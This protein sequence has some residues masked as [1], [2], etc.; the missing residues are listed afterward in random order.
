MV[1]AGN[2]QIV[3]KANAMPGRY[4]VTVNA[5]YDID[6]VRAYAAQLGGTVT[7]VWYYAVFGFAMQ[8]STQVATTL[9]LDSRVTAVEQD[10]A[11][12]S[13][14]VCPITQHYPSQTCA[15]GSIPWQLD[16]MDSSAGTTPDE[17]GGIK[18][19][20]GA[21]TYHY[22]GS[23]VRI[24]SIDSGIHD[25]A[26]ISGR[27]VSGISL[28]YDDH[29][30]DD[31][32]GHGTTCA[33]IAAG[34]KMGPAKN[35]QLIAVR[36]WDTGTSASAL[37]S[38]LNWV[39]TDIMTRSGSFRA[40]V[41]I[42]A[43]LGGS[44]AIDTAARKVAQMAVVVTA[45][46][47]FAKD[48]C[49]LSPQRIPEVIVAAAVQRTGAYETDKYAI[50]SFSGAGAC[51]ALLAPGVGLGAAHWIYGDYNCNPGQDGTSVASALTAGM[52]ALYLERYPDASN[53]QIKQLMLAHASYE[54]I[55]GDM[56][57][58]PSLLVQR[59]PSDYVTTPENCMP[60]EYWVNG[61]SSSGQ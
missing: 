47:N 61:C 45:A 21:Y 20:D 25:H 35:A 36:A 56:R 46:G 28:V 12:D 26:D 48:A 11:G 59:P 18:H 17:Y 7:D 31:L 33:S 2:G 10:D 19:L 3:P 30:T 32:S 53:A 57:G 39:A 13:P 29:G 50:A 60:C 6:T 40:V 15:D 52:A 34:T 41:L 27:L 4:I 54:H 9:S 1:Y 38:A 24:Y 42:E 51:V 5:A 58:A 44:N 22:T 37:V 16:A 23:G 14:G 43:Q 49:Q 55:A 8:S